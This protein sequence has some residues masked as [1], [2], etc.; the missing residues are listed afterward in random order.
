MDQLHIYHSPQLIKQCLEQNIQINIELWPP[1]SSCIVLLTSRSRQISSSGGHSGSTRTT[2]AATVSG[3][4]PHVAI[5][6]PLKG[7]NGQTL[8][9]GKCTCKTSFSFFCDVLR[10]CESLPHWH[11]VRVFLCFGDFEALQ[12]RTS[13]AVLNSINLQDFWLILSIFYRSA[14]LEIVTILSVMIGCENILY[15][16]S[17]SHRS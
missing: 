1:P 13:M 6:R 15:F 16:N 2:G 4:R 10:P 5:L 8:H 17:P 14:V 11:H 7:K 3:G 12:P 9:I